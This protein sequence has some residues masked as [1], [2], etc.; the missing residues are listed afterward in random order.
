MSPAADNPMTGTTTMSAK[1]SLLVSLALMAVA[2]SSPA[3]AQELITFDK[4]AIDALPSTITPSKLTVLRLLQPGGNV[5]VVRV[6]LPANT[7]IAPHPH[8]A[9]KVAV[10]TVLSGD[11]KVGLGNSF[12][13]AALKPVAPGGMF[14]FRET[15]PQHFA[16]TGN[17]P[18][19]LLLV[20]GPKESVSPALLGAK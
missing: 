8:P 20:A 7:D 19:E 12:S 9:G 6:S 10:V 11:F 15:D 5:V 3:A 13:E 4:K 18:V 14:V 16:R 1:S 2:T 17:G